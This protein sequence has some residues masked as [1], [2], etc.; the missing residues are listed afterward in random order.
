M[1]KLLFISTPV[2]ALGTGQGGGV[3]LTIQNVAQELQQRGYKIEVVAPIGSVLHNIPVKEIPGNLQIAVQTQGRDT[4]ICLPPNSALA[5]MLDY[6]RQVQHEY[7]L[8]VN[9]AFDWLPFYLTPFFHC[10]IAHFISMGSMTE[11]LDQIMT[12]VAT[13]Y[14]QTIGVYT[15]SQAATFPFA[16]TCEIL[17]SAIDLSLYQFVPHPEKT[18]AWLGRIAPEKALEDA[19]AAVNTT[20]TPLKIYGKIQDQDYWQQ[21]Q[22]DFPHAPIEYMGFLS[23][24]ELQQELGQ[25]RAL[26]MTPRWIEAFGNVAIEALA[27]GV[28][29]IAYRRGGPA[30]IVQD[31]V[32]GFLVEPDSIEGLVTA[33]DQIDLI[34]RRK[35]RQQAE[36][37]YSLT[38][39]GDRFSLWF[40][41]IL[42]T[43]NS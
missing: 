23:T 36:A 34:D 40:D 10:P 16:D 25:C 22:Q 11:A 29:V 14:P 15:K 18:L 30:E 27:C 39:L 38:A 32:T 35:C 20:G 8:I 37:E 41:P 5:N 9:F 13:N 33:I 4:P 26:L 31:G 43:K 1:L 3:E 12:Q 2:G 17:S 21:I 24:Q 7:D 19:V 6:A 28:P 42:K